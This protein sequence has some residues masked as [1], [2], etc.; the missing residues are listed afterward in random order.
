MR[1]FQCSYFFLQSPR[2][3]YASRHLLP[4]T[5]HSNKDNYAD[6]QWPTHNTLGCTWMSFIHKWHCHQL[7]QLPIQLKS[8]RKHGSTTTSRFMQI[9]I[10]INIYI[11]IWEFCFFLFILYNVCVCMR[12]WKIYVCKDKNIELKQRKKIRKKEINTM[13]MSLC[14]QLNSQCNN[15]QRF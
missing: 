11:C 12:I 4:S 2:Q 10:H 8:R 1:P 3:P 9:Y 15:K 14:H 7:S 5:C 6:E 13:R